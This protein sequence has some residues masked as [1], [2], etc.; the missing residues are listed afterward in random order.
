MK[1]L[2]FRLSDDI[3]DV[4]HS[5]QQ[6]LATTTRLIPYMHL[7]SILKHSGSLRHNYFCSIAS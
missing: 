5:R 6:Q 3:F 1:S 7:Q 2:P 4:S